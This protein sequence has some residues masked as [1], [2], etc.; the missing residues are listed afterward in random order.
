MQTP[1]QDAAAPPANN[2]CPENY[3]LTETGP[4]SRPRVGGTLV[5]LPGNRAAIFGGCDDIPNTPPID[6]GWCPVEVYEE[7][8]GR[9]TEVGYLQHKR[10]GYAAAHLREGEVLLVGGVDLQE[11]GGSAS[12]EIFDTSTGQSR[13]A[14]PLPDPLILASALRLADGRVLV[15]GGW[16]GEPSVRMDHIYLPE[17]DEWQ[18]VPLSSTGADD[19]VGLVA[20]YDGALSIGQRL[21]YAL[22]QGSPGPRPMRLP[23]DV[24]T[25]T[26]TFGQSRAVSAS[27]PRSPA[28]MI[29]HD[30][31]FVRIS[32]TRTLRWQRLWEPV[33]SVSGSPKGILSFC[34][35]ALII[36][37]RRE[38]DAEMLPRLPSNMMVYEGRPPEAALPDNSFAG[39]VQ[40][41]AERGLLIRGNPEG[42]FSPSTRTYLYAPE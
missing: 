37:T 29:S 34:S 6:P 15:S 14:E 19:Y 18:A 33:V 38:V 13:L 16:D 7:S 39:A 10:L 4:L 31:W 3:V 23:S 30:G 40:L 1:G 20:L 28:A 12:V 5:A 32:S 21:S 42:D 8:T 2:N 22:D 35:H 36:S 11:N 24:A 27:L 41:D 9:W 26:L 25:R 17:Q